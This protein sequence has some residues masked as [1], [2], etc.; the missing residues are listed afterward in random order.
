MKVQVIFSDNVCGIPADI[1]TRLFDPFFTT[2]PVGKGTGMGLSTSYQII[3]Q[4]HGGIVECYSQ[5]GQGSTFILTIPC[6]QNE[7]YFQH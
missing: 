3:T 4:K 6:K 2:K 5:E 7:K 1:L